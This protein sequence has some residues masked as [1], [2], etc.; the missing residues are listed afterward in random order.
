MAVK[1]TSRR[2]L[3]S[4]GGGA[5]REWQKSGTATM[6]RD[7]CGTSAQEGGGL[8][9][10]ITG[11]S[12]GNTTATMGV[13]AFGSGSVAILGA[14]LVIVA[15]GSRWFINYLLLQCSNKYVVYLHFAIIYV[16]V[17]VV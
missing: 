16:W 10:A 8:G 7:R 5:T 11:C 4:G 9:S 15:V 1:E 17:H 14:V 2:H 13:Y 12:R 3:I 6:A